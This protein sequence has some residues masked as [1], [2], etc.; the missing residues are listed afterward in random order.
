VW[1]LRARLL[2][3]APDSQAIACPLSGRNSTYRPVQ[4]SATGSIQAMARQTARTSA[5]F[6]EFE[7]QFGSRVQ[8]LAQS[9]SLLI[10]QDWKGVSLDKLIETQLAPFV[11]IDTMRIEAVG[12]PVR[13]ALAPCRHSGWH[14]TN[15]RPMR[16]NMAA[17][18][19]AGGRVVLSWS[20]E[21]E[22]DAP[23]SFRMEWREM[24]GPPV[25]PSTRKGFGRFVIDQMVTRPQRDGQNGPCIGRIVLEIANA[26][27]RGSCSGVIRSS[28]ARVKQYSIVFE[29]RPL[30]IHARSGQVESMKPQR[31]KI[32]RCSP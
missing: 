21:D 22:K 19:A 27:K 30:N 9:N 6:A 16:R 32:A 15:L 10:D 12:P 14:C 8:G 25:K 11:G 29:I 18:S 5:T 17:L 4:N 1:F 2:M 26:R 3:V 31:L 20:F 28:N 24:G 7:T 23:E 13:L